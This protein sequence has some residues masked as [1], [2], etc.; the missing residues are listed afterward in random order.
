MIE[1][2]AER[3][4]LPTIQWETKE[5]PEAAVEVIF[6]VIPCWPLTDVRV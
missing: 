5:K 4:P 6:T 1:L 2:P 3:T